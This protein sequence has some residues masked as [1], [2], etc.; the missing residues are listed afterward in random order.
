[1]TPDTA[2]TWQVSI[3]GVGSVS[4]VALDPVGVTDGVGAPETFNIEVSQLKSGGFKGLG[5]TKNHPAQQAIQ[6]AISKRLMDARAV[7]NFAPDA[8]LTRAEL[9][10]YLVM[11]AN[12]R[13]HLPFT[14]TSK[15]AADIEPS[16]PLYPT[17]EAVLATGGVLRDLTFRSPAVMSLKLDSTGKRVFMPSAAASRLDVAQ[18]LVKALG[19]AAV[20]AAQ[21]GASTVTFTPAG[22]PTVTVSDLASLSS[23]DR[24]YVQQAINN[25][26]MVPVE[27][28]GAWVFE[29]NRAVKRAEYAQHADA[30]SVKF[31]TGEDGI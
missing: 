21:A 10:T 4:G 16:N 25:G 3:R 28:S 17:V 20:A 15:A 26:I 27:K 8:D 13:Q 11:G 24:G 23:V 12:I 22:K 30:F 6:T 2:G 31:R 9:A 18:A 7:N 14:A 1:V 29:P 5:D 19:P